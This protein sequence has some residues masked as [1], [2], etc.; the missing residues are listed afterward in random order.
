MRAR[1]RRAPAVA[2]RR[3]RAPAAALQLRLGARA[4]RRLPAPN[5]CDALPDRHFEALHG[6][7]LV[8]EVREHDARQ[9]LAD[10]LFNGS[11]IVLL[12]R[13]HEG[14]RLAGELCPRRAAHAMDVVLGHP[15]HVE[16]DDVAER[17]DIDA[18]L[19]YTSP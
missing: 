1:G 17:L 12:F 6:P 4:I 11:E 13:R 5:L 14:V 8:V 19:L 18:C 9:T 7:L 10:R 16:V 2:R 3:A 15:R